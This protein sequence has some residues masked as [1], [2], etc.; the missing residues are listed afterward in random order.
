MGK[1]HVQAGLLAT[2]SGFRTLTGLSKDQFKGGSLTHTNRHRAGFY[3]FQS[4]DKNDLIA[5]FVLAT[6]RCPSRRAFVNLPKTILGK[7][8]YVKSNG[9]TISKADRR[10]PSFLLLQAIFKYA[11]KC[12]LKK[13]IRY[14]QK[15]IL[16][17]AIK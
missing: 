5:F 4:L 6:M 17:L 9:A 2:L 11:L 1:D 7:I 10:N 12:S 14:C 15:M 8:K 13:Q 16:S 3:L